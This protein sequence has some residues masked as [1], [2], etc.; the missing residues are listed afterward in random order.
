MQTYKSKMKSKLLILPLAFMI[1]LSPI[2][3]SSTNSLLG[4]L[5]VKFSEQRSK[6]ELKGCSLEYSSL[7]Q[8]HSYNRGELYAVF[9]SLSISQNKSGTPLIGLKVGTQK[10]VPGTNGSAIEFI[11]ERPHFA[12]LTDENGANNA[13]QLIAS[14]DSDTPGAKFF[15]YNLFTEEA[16]QLTSALSAKQKLIIAFNRREGGIDV[17]LPVDLTVIETGN[18][19][20][21]RK[22]PSEALA[23]DKCT[24]K[25]IETFQKNLKLN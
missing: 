22:S 8:D 5:F 14:T 4:T 9:G 12:Y 18:D 13:K 10:V 25:I 6:G 19:G 16:I 20:Q 17:F 2:S 1:P 15:V 23:F 7:I 11:P 21:R 3:A 24:L